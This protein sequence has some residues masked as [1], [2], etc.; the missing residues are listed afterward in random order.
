MTIY[1]DEYRTR[2]L[3]G[4]ASC[5]NDRL[6][7]VAHRHGVSFKYGAAIVLNCNMV[8]PVG[9]IFKRPTCGFATFWPAS[10]H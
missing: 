5:D 1:I 4:D 9:H 2:Q 7:F 6:T 8:D 10:V 3:R